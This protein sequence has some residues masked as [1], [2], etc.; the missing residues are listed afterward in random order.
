MN[1]IVESFISQ[2]GYFSVF[3][4]MAIEST[5]F[6]LPS[7]AVL[8]VASIFIKKN[9][10]NFWGVVF[11]ATLGS[12]FGSIFSYLIGYL[13]YNVFKKIFLRF[14]F[15][16]LKI[17]K[18]EKILNKYGILGVFLGRFLPGVRHLI[19][20]PAGFL[21]L[22]FVLF[23]VFTLLGSFLWCLFLT[24]LFFKFFTLI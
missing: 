9:I 4:L 14:S 11:S 16:D 23:F 12:L 3:V 8:G 22:N 21:R 17:Q 24:Y 15:I 1:Q 6:P 5:I 13:V 7:E 19:S 18:S 10:L 20:Y 2:Y